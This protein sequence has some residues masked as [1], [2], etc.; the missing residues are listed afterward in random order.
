MAKWNSTFDG[1]V[2]ADPEER[3]FDNGGSLVELPIYINHRRK[4][5]E[6]WVDA[7][8]SKVKYIASGEYGESLKQFKKGNI[9]KVT[10][11]VTE[12]RE[13]E[14]G[15]KKGISI[16]ARFGTI[17]LLHEGGKPAEG[18]GNWP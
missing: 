7:G 1:R 13:W 10:D 16:E 5:G 18:G 12:A 8:T 3:K 2:V 11:A 14:S 17:E 6:E 9:V 4:Q 15:E